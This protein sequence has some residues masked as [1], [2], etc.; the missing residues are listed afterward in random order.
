[1]LRWFNLCLL[2]LYP[3]AWYAPLIR[4]GLLPLFGL[5]EISV[6]TGIR[7]L[8]SSDIFLALLVSA[9]ALVAPLIKTLC[10]SLVHF[11]LLAPRAL[12]VLTVVGKLA[13]ADVFLIALYVTL[14]KG[15]GVGR[16]ET[17]WGLYLFTFCILASI[18]IGWR[19]EQSCRAGR[20]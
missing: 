8:W 5:T 13:M 20:Y 11:G 12:P 10:L 14:F 16:I 1:M 15:M 2:V 9:F 7:S 6:L 17:A 3:L 18:L 19:T 4:T